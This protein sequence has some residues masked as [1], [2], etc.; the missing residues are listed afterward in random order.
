[1]SPLFTINFRREAYVREASRRR[2]RVIALGVWVA[3]FGV[4]LVL[5]GLY[6]LNGFSLV[7]RAHLIERQTTLIR[8][9]KSGGSGTQLT[10]GDL[11]QVE[12]FA[13][14]TRQWRDRMERLSALLPPDARLSALAVNPQ[15]QSDRASSNA[16]AIRGELKTATG[17]DR[18]QGVMKIVSSLRSDSVFG[19]GYRNIKL[20][21]TSISDDGSVEFEI[22]CR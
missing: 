22:E 17:P 1:V 7:R 5:I 20:A 16:L 10:Q 6:A 15:N 19:L 2:R 9:T 13:R 21:S 18:M 14:S 4:L 8:S 11:E 3:Y 12:S